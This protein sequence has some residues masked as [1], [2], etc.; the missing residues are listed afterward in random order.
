MGHMQILTLWEDGSLG[1]Q[2]K[3]RDLSN[4]F[5]SV[6]VGVCCLWVIL[7]WCS[8]RPPILQPSAAFTACL[9]GPVLTLFR[10]YLGISGLLARAQL[11]PALG[12]PGC[13]LAAWKSISAAIPKPKQCQVPQPHLQVSPQYCRTIN[14]QAFCH[15]NVLLSSPAAWLDQ[16][17]LLLY[18]IL[19]PVASFSIVSS[20]QP[21]ANPI[22]A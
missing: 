21:E 22:H 2:L 7:R 12:E 8:Y 14:A 6:F 5:T 20:N 17:H 15:S 16:Q 11:A 18:L 19:T 13:L 9:A 10:K 3:R 1:K 4:S